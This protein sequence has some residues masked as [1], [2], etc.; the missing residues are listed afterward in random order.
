MTAMSRPFFDQIDDELR[1][2][3]GPALRGYGCARGARLVKLWYAHPAV[4]FEVQAVGVRW[5]PL[6]VPAL[7][8]GLHLE[9]PDPAVNVALL[10][11]LEGSQDAWRKILPAAAAGPGLGPRGSR[12]R[13]VSEFLAGDASEDPDLASEAAEILATY[14][15]TLWPLLAGAAEQLASPPANTAQR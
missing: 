6:P 2:L 10:G 5:S 13:R 4:H 9:H 12:W 15:R 8:V 1:G 11:V 3:L 14:I 7:E